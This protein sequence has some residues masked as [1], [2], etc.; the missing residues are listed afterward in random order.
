MA[1]ITP[2]AGYSKSF[3]Q[4]IVVSSGTFAATTTPDVVI[5]VYG[6]SN[7]TLSNETAASVVEVSYDGGTVH[8][9][10]DS[11]QTTKFLQY[12]NRPASTIWFR[13]KSG[14]AATVSIRAW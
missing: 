6:V 13:L 1:T 2:R 8:D 12:L 10:L 9:E 11:T 4:K 3:F 14:A 7:F 5:N